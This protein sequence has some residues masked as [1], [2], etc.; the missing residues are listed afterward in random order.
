MIDDGSEIKMKSSDNPKAT[1][2]YYDINH[3]QMDILEKFKIRLYETKVLT[4]FTYYDD[5]YLLRFLRAR[6]FDIEKAFTMI[7]DFFKWRIKENVD[8]AE[9]FVY[10]EIL[11]VKK[12]YPHTYHKTD[13]KVKFILF[14]NLGK[15]SLYRKFRR[16]E[17]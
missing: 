13:K 11:E 5:L 14:K 2:F 16:N 10:D 8:E 7:S 3:K 15:T 4:D 12:V 1:G 17:N 6:K 9:H